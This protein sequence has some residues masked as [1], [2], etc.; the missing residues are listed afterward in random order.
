MIFALIGPDDPIAKIMIDF[1]KSMHGPLPTRIR[2]STLGKTYIE[3][4]YIYPVE[5]PKPVIGSRYAAHKS[6]APLLAILQNSRNP[7]DAHQGRV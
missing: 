7:R 6:G 2:G 3:N 1:Q 4:A 5:K